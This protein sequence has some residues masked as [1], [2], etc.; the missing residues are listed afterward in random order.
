MASPC[1]YHPAV[2]ST[3]ACIQCGMPICANCTEQVTGRTVCKK[4]S[5]SF[6]ACMEQQMTATPAAAQT[7]QVPYP[8]YVPQP[9]AGVSGTQTPPSAYGG[10]AVVGRQSDMKGVLIGLGLV[11]GIIGA[12]I[13][14]KILFYAHFGLSLLYVAMG[15]GIGWGIHRV[16]GRGG[17]GLALAAVGV[18]AVALFVGQLF[19]AQDILNMV[20]DAG[21]ADASATLFDALPVSVTHLGPMHWVCMAFGLLAC[22][23]GVEQQQ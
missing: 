9:P 22:Y 4:C 2:S 23:R 16:T 5:P 11:I 17:T 19:Y 18:M 21:R 6:K 7:R 1:Y 8:G 10:A 20:R 12:V 3:G 14:E 15:Y 13:I